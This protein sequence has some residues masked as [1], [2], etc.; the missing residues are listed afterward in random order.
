MKNWMSRRPETVADWLFLIAAGVAIY[1]VFAHL[2]DIGG[3]LGTV[4]GILSPF[5]GAV[6]LAYLLDMPTR[7]FAKT[8]FK[9]KRGPA[10][11]ASYLC[12]ILAI[13]LLVSLV[14]PQLGASITMFANNLPDYARNL[15]ALLTTLQ[16]EYD[17]PVDMLIDLLA[18]STKNFEKIMDT[19]ASAMPAV[20][21]YAANAM[22]SVVA[23]FTSVAGSIYMLA[24]KESLL[25]NLRAALYALLPRRA[26]QSVLGVF[27]MANRTFSSYIGGQMID[28]LLVGI[29]TFVLMTVFG[30]NFAP[31]I[32]VLV[33]VTNVIPIF[34]PFIGAVPSAI[35]LLFADPIQAVWFAILILVVQQIDG[36]FIAPR[37][38]GDSI[39][40]S[41]LWV[42]MAIILGG[43][44]FGLPGMVV[45][46]PLFGVV[47]ALLRESVDA[48]LK[49]RGIDANGDPLP[50]DAAPPTGG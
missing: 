10:I 43:D 18:D 27:S 44:L 32:A 28:A 4:L 15:Q 30:L 7:F 2:P 13:V 33:G 9:G 5:A 47:Y 3:A 1:F 22:S 29:E 23:V 8:L 21:S 20:A 50:P 17:L 31:L 35:I 42:L 25:R 24:S 46:V 12:A 36:N 48:S 39:G 6:V 34:G 37:I 40:L 16:Q 26:V 14:V 49:S 41:G 11:V 38:L 19:I 45:G